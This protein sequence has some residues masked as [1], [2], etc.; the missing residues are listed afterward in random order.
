MLQMLGVVLLLLGFF[1][2]QKQPPAP[3]PS[4]DRISGVVVDALS[5]QPLAGATVSIS[6]N[7][8]NSARRMTTGEDGTFVFEGVA[9]GMYVLSGRRHG[10]VT[11]NYEEHEGFT[12]GIAVGPGLEPENLRLT[13]LPMATISGEVRDEQGDA[14]R[15]APVTL[16]MQANQRGRRRVQTLMR[17]MTDDR[18]DYRFSELE[19]GTYYVGVKARPWY[20]TNIPRRTLQRNGNVDWFGDNRQYEG[21]LDVVYPVTYFTNATDFAGAAPITLHAGDAEA[22]DFRLLPVPALHVL[23]KLPNSEQ[24]QNFYFHVMQSFGEDS[25]DFVPASSQYVAPGL[26]ELGG[27]PPGRL[28]LTVGT[29][30]GNEPWAR[31]QQLDLSSDMQIDAAE[32]KPGVNVRGVVKLDSGAALERPAN[33]ELRDIKTGRI[34]G[35]QTDSTGA[36]AFNQEEVSP[37][38]YEIFVFAEPRAVLRDVSAMGAKLVGHTL[39]IS[40]TEDVRVTAIET[41]ASGQITGIAQKD[42]KPVGGVM[43]V[44]VPPD[45]ENNLAEFRRDQSNTD[46]SFTLTTISPGMYTLLAIENGWDLE[47]ANPSVLQKYLPGGEK[48]QVGPGAKIETK[49]KVQ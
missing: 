27:L 9:P 44:L 10:Y 42:G 22:A 45:P 19:P 35:V 24:P 5:G 26:M 1:P 20:A 34:T 23:V 3:K 2:Q 18:G 25:Q 6:S 33:V 17:M 11:Q 47:W 7:V 29:N 13:L 31:S 21:Q 36:F 41:M 38:N 4:S 8:Q 16:F 49:L 28:Q 37:G 48:V 46:G 15:E 39:Q 40:G 14:V 32:I 12:T 43:V 30:A